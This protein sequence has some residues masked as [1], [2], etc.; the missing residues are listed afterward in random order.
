[1][2]YH[3]DLWLVTSVTIGLWLVTSVYIGLWLVVTSI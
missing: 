3:I 1:M 2:F